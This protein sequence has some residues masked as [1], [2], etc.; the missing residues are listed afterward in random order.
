MKLIRLLPLSLVLLVLGGIFWP[1]IAP[2]QGRIRR[3]QVT[4][5]GVPWGLTLQTDRPYYRLGDAADVL[6]TLSN[7]SRR[8]TVGWTLV[9]G[10]NGCRYA[11]TIVDSLGQTV[12][13][14]GRII[15]GQFSG[16]G[17]TFGTTVVNLPSR[18]W[19]QD[20]RRIPLAYQ[21]AGGIGCPT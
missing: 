19:I 16:P 11:I 9:G 12:W 15:Q 14:P 8:D 6:Y 5:L 21:N 20:G 3:Q 18:T 17:C 2:T 10:G 13:Q 1:R 7:N 4:P